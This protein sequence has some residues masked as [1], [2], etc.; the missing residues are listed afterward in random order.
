MKLSIKDRISKSIKASK[1]NVFVRS[2]FKKFGGYDQVGRALKEV[3]ENGSLVKMGYGVYSKA[4]KSA[5]S[6][7]PIPVATVTEAG[8]VVMNKLGV[9]ADVGYFARLYRDGKTTQIPMKEVIA[10]SKPI[11]RKIYFGKR[12][13]TYE[14]Y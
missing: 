10:V 9:K 6:G 1:A 11:T 4:E 5:L 12:V 3:I 2:D 8:L 14:K 13:L 7:K